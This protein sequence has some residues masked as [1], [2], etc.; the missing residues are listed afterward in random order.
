MKKLI[1]KVNQFLLERYPTL[2]NTKIIWVVLVS[3]IVH[4]LFFIFG[5]FAL[6]NP[7]LLQEY[8]ARYIFF[9][10]GTVFLNVILSILILV[11]WL[12]NMFKNNAF[13]EFYPSS[14]LRL[15][16]Q[17]ICYLIIIFV[18]TTFYHTY[19]L[20]LKTYITNTY[21]DATISEEIDISNRTAL[22][23]SKD[24]K[25][26]TV[27]QIRYPDIFTEIYCETR[28]SAIDEDRTHFKFLDFTYQFYTLR[29]KKGLI[30]DR[31]TIEEAIDASLDGYVF[32]RVKDSIITYYYKDS[33]A[34]VGPYLKTGWP[35]YF[36]YSKTFYDN[37]K[38]EEDNELIYND[39]AYNE[40]DSDGQLLYSQKL[41]QNNQRNY[42][43]LKRNHPSE[44][45]SMLEDFLNI[46]KSYKVRHNIS[47]NQWFDL[48]YHPENFE[49]KSLIND[50]PR[51]D[52]GI[53][54]ELTDLEKFINDHTTDFYIET[55][56]LHNV[57]E[58]I[59][60]IKQA[61]I[62]EENIHL[63]IWL[64][65]FLSS[66]I[67]IFR[68]TGL[69]SL[70]FS[71]I[72]VG[73]LCVF[74]ALLT[75]LYGYISFNHSGNSVAYFISYL[76]LIIGAII[77]VIPLCF[78]KSL[79]KTVVSICLNISLVGFVLY[80]LLIIAIISLYQDEWCRNS[81]DYLNQKDCFVL[82][83]SL[84]LNLS[85]VLLGIGLLFLY[86]YMGVVKRWKSLPEK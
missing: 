6:K 8:S 43:L 80:V 13:K 19:N 48:V 53:T 36:N 4:L 28:L 3:M 65:F 18:S 42:E 11:V 63:F 27:D 51:E 7:E 64:S 37:Y 35:S 2:W 23:F 34:D 52:Y 15:F 62:I 45:R 59:D 72:T 76:T 77:L 79:N 30:K 71:I 78:S 81:Y 17:F 33:L 85:Y 16:L 26:Y 73:V 1:F 60:D 12:I 9:D 47:S 75:S 21:P 22:F 57:F 66:V 44:I 70:L 54:A 74:V 14:K 86:F 68:M 5:F 31:N 49:V 46:A 83:T 82:I 32:S 20:G 84:G 25:D 50:K 69:A 39:H 56:K 40:Y 24:I 29:S 55:D 61:P 10:N 38:T 67:F 58:N 41:L